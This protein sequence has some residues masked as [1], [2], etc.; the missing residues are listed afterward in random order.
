MSLR[1]RLAEAP[2]QSYAYAYPH[3]TAY[4]ELAEPVDLSALWAREDRS[5]LFGYVHVPFCS[6]RCGFCNLFA[7]GRPEDDLVA[8]YVEQLS[9]QIAVLGAAL[10]EH[11]FARFA[12]GGG[13]PSYLDAAQLTA[14]F[15]AVNRHWHINLQDIPAGIEVSPETAK[16]ERLRVCREAGVDRVSM[17]VQSFV[18]AELAALVRPTQRAEVHAAIEVV[19]RLG[20]ATL[21]LDLIYGIAGQSPG[22]LRQSVRAALDFAPE[23]IYLYPLY[24]RP[25]TGLGRI[26]SRQQGTAADSRLP[27]YR[28]AR[29]QLLDAGYTQVSMRMFRAPHAPDAGGPAY[30]CQNDGMVG[31]GCGARSYTRTLHYSDRYGVARTSV[32][33]IIR[34]YSGQA[35]EL[36]REARLG[37]VLDADEQRRRFVIQSL[38]VAPG[39]EQAAY[40]RRFG[41]ELWQDLPCLGELIDN[42]L[43]H[44]VDGVL[45]LTTT[46]VEHADTI[47]PWLASDA[48]NARMSSYALA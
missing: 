43:A 47:G 13:T 17:G 27:L 41:T 37:F 21:N 25:K 26:A 6:Y 31:V 38:L 3:K 18:D 5:A 24:V 30:C 33:D 23:E 7:L 35:P 10:G 44:C 19:R 28:A 36:F 15:E 32:A 45:A 1:D 9:R 42:G 8:G 46:G 39:L 14:V 4:R 11:R 29:D 16:G 34:Q 40:R 22:S 20:F 12:L 2:Y 48:V